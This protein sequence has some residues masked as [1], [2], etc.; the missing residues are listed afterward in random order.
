MN[1]LLLA[2]Q[3]LSNRRLTAILT[4]FSIAI[5][6]ALL[7]GVSQV[8]EQTKQSF[9]RTV[10][11]TDLIVGARSS[12]VN[13]LLYSVF[14]I[15]NATN[16]ID[17][18]SYQMVKNHRA[19]KW[20]IPLSLGDSHRGFRVLGTNQNYFT[21]LRYGKKQPLSFAKGWP[22]QG[23]F[24]TVIGAEVAQKLGY[25]VG[26]H[27]IIA[28]GIS[29]QAFNRHDNLP[30]TIVGILN[31]TGTPVDKSVHVSL[32]AIEAI[33]VGWQ[34][35]AKIGQ[36]PSQSEL[37]NHP[38]QPKQLTAVMVGLNS[39]VQ[40][41]ALQRQLNQYRG[42]ALSAI[43]PGVA[44]Q[45][46]WQMMNIAEKA[47]TMVSVF[48]VIA[49]LL[50]MLTSML[51][52]LNERRREM[53]ILRAMGARP[54]HIY[55]LLCSEALLLSTLG[56]AL[57]IALLMLTITGLSPWVLN[58]FGL[59]LSTQWPTQ[60]EWLILLVVLIIGTLVGL[61]PARRAYRQSLADGM[62]IRL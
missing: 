37:A 27:I 18:Q 10:S 1:M 56:I 2:W 58:Q 11:G 47:L 60:T 43:L 45:E 24:E 16:N 59:A 51:T 31:P 13:L 52:S 14:R 20:T 46:L 3:S 41:F 25:Q 50:G 54:K 33:H 28:H 26:D 38:F 7:L 32:E 35:G 42:E 48:V 36:T 19:V 17:W 8:R 39:R 30:F 44:L 29:D 9:T 61:I 21:Y 57:G 49:G 53:A 4:I 34:S 5:S 23:L 55:W 12:Q 62:N 15:G 22:F 40:A 6:V